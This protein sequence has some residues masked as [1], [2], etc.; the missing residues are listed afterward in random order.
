MFKGFTFRD[1]TSDIEP[2]IEPVVETIKYGG[3][4]RDHQ[5]EVYKESLR[6][7]SAEGIH[8]ICYNFMPRTLP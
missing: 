1:L 2:I 8:C 4:D 3:P 6:N 5:I 7:L